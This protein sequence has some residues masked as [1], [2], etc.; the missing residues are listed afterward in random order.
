MDSEDGIDVSEELNSLMFGYIT[1]ENVKW[2]AIFVEAGERDCASGVMLCQRYGAQNPLNEWRKPRCR[3]P[4]PG[5]QA[6]VK[7]LRCRKRVKESNS[8]EVSV[9]SLDAITIATTPRWSKQHRMNCRWLPL[10]LL[11]LL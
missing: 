5:G 11:S 7:N 10:F 4:G 6:A 1:M 3:E 9:M 2:D 8:N